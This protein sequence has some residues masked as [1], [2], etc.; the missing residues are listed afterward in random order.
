MIEGTCLLLTHTF[1]PLPTDFM[2]T[3]D[4]EALKKQYFPKNIDTMEMVEGQLDWGS[5]LP[6]LIFVFI[7][8]FACAVDKYR[9]G[10]LNSMLP[11][12]CQRTVPEQPIMVVDADGVNSRELVAME[13]KEK[14]LPATETK[15]E[16]ETETET[17]TTVE[18][19]HDVGDDSSTTPTCT[20]TAV[21]HDVENS[22]TTIEVQVSEKAD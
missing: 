1:F 12:M 11:L 19:K 4:F 18:T 17:A 14:G 22:S 6:V 2:S 10:E 3:E 5:I 8:F 7:Y 20:P 15:A 13:K 16:T 9:A 21:E